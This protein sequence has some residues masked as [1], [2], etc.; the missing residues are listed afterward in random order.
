MKR[1]M[2]IV[3][4]IIA[5]PVVLFL[6]ALGIYCIVNLQGVIEPFNV[7][8]PDAHQ[9]I[10]IGSQGSEFKEALVSSFIGKLQN[11]QRFFSVMDCTQLDT[12]KQEAWDAV[13]L[14]HTLQVH[15]MPQAAHSF[16]E[17]ASDLDKVIL[18]S[19]S[20]AGDEHV[21]DFEVDGIS[22]ASRLTAVEP[23]VEWA[24]PRLEERLSSTPHQ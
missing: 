14:I 10:L 23:I 11:D 9:R 5:T 21:E 6:T 4:A 2:K 7:G 19:V 12:T 24:V 22:S 1:L 20:G 13:L 18:V 15:K 16:L 17:Q 3:I 8:N